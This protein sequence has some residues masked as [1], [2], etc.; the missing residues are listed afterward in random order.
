MGQC[1]RNIALT[2][3]SNKRNLKFKLHPNQINSKVPHNRSLSHNCQS[4]GYT[5]CPL[6]H[7]S[8]GRSHVIHV[9]IGINPAWNG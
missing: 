8:Q 5:G 2:Q 3:K 9:I 7:I 6:L 4:P 1:N